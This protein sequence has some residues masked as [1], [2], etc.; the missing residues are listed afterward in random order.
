MKTMKEVKARFKEGATIN[1]VNHNQPQLSGDRKVFKL[2]T[3]WLVLETPD[4]RGSWLRW[5]K[6]G[7]MRI[8]GPNVVTFLCGEKLN[9]AAPETPFITVT[10]PE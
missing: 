9:P 5:P 7:D 2:Q 1:V 4:G 6:A 8:K 10:F 3:E